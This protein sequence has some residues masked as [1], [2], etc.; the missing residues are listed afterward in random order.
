V[1]PEHR[2]KFVRF[3]LAFL[4][5]V[6]IDANTIASIPPTVVETSVY[7]IEPDRSSLLFQA[8]VVAL[9]P[10]FAR[11]FNT[12]EEAVKAIEDTLNNP[13]LTALPAQAKSQLKAAL[14]ERIQS[15]KQIHRTGGGERIL[16]PRLNAFPLST[17]PS[18]SPVP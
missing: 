16:T 15:R 11:V 6:T 4:D 9:N 2:E 10:L 12:R 18:S 1:L 13:P 7:S 3:T 14:E 5:I 8:N 17:P